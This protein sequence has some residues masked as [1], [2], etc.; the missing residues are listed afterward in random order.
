MTKCLMPQLLSRDGIKCDPLNNDYDF[1]KDAGKLPLSIL[2]IG[3]SKSG[4]T[5]LARHLATRLDV[6]HIEVTIILNALFKKIAEY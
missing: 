1:I 6:V 3:N 2:I 4:K 5:T